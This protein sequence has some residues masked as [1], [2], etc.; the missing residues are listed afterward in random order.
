[1]IEIPDDT[2]V[3]LLEWLAQRDEALT[4]IRRVLLTGSRTWC[5]GHLLRQV[6][7][8]PRW[9]ADAVLVHGGARGADTLA[10]QLWTGWLERR[11]EV[12]ALPDGWWR[13]PGGGQVPLLRDQRMVDAG[14]DVCLA[15]I[16]QNSKGAST[17]AAMAEAARIQTFR[18]RQEW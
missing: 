12:H 16:R 10:D 15:F 11:S 2:L 7:S 1:V 8:V 17:T 6:L 18:F 3:S 9:P 4:P 14:A 13:G 5:A